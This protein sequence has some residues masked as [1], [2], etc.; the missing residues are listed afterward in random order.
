[1][2]A[3][4]ALVALTALICSATAPR[5]AHAQTKSTSP[6]VVSKAVDLRAQRL[7]RDSAR[8]RAAAQGSPIRYYNAARGSAVFVRAAV[9]A[10]NRAAVGTHFVAVRRR[11]AQVVI[12]PAP[13]RAGCNGVAIIKGS[14]ASATH[15]V[16]IRYGYRTTAVVKLGENCALPEGRTLIAVHEL[17]HVL[18]LH[19]Q[20]HRCS[21]MSPRL[22]AHNGS[23]VRPPVCS[24]GAWERLLSR[25]VASGDVRAARGLYRDRNK[26]ADTLPSNYGSGFA[27]L[28][29][30]GVIVL[31]GGLLA[32]AVTRR[33]R[34]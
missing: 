30:W 12:R 5:A 33:P 29:L 4:I 16:P 9:R 8:R 21:V 25:S 3:S 28:W 20:R 1:M 17:G 15:D 7:A 23:L 19:H 26:R 2:P 24:P 31:G 32:Y 11:A 18:G 6:T 13:P 22:D 27:P 14:Q 10:W 34:R